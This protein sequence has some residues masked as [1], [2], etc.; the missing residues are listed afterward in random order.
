MNLLDRWKD[1]RLLVV[2]GKGGVGKSTVAATLGRVLAATGR[3]VLLLEADPRESL[4][5]LLEVEPSGGEIV[6]A[7]AGLSVQNV[8]PKDVLDHIVGERL[9]IDFLTKKVTR[10]PVYNHFIEG[11]PG[12]KEMALLGHAYTQIKE[13]RYDLVLLDAPATGHGLS[14]LAAPMLVSDA[15]DHGPVGE[16]AGEL[17]D[18]VRDPAMVGAV[19]VTLAEEMP[20]QES[21]ELI[22]GLQKRLKR[23]PELVVVNS[24]YPLTADGGE[25]AAKA[26]PDP[27]ELGAAPLGRKAVL[28]LWRQRAGV[29]R[30][31]LAH[32]T[33]EWKGPRID[34]P[35]VA[36]ET[37]A[38]LVRALQTELGNGLEATR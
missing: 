3:R 16:L 23:L 12:L 7:G 37:G 35:M 11:A 28:D 1:R 2:T 27:I 14:M 33:R 36:M 29:N 4:Y 8:Q 20:V 26:E 30:E 18:F 32:L 9:K 13:S 22:Q 25:P 15:I 10:S 19:L 21:L 24:L 5:P 34:L 38:G 31:E 17:A 6:D